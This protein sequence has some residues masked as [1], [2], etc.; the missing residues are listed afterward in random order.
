MGPSL[1]GL[2]GLLE[3]PFGC[4]EQNMINFAP[5]ISIARYLQSTKQLENMSSAKAKAIRVIH[6]G[7][8]IEKLSSP[9][10][11]TR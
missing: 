2:E 7:K 10:L 4:G 3:M 9:P 8:S 6:S 1:E 11:R 5:G